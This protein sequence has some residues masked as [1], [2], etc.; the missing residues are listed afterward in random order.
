MPWSSDLNPFKIVFSS[1]L[2]LTDQK[3]HSSLHSWV[4]FLT[5]SAGVQP[6]APIP[7]KMNLRAPVSYSLCQK[8]GEILGSSSTIFFQCKYHFISYLELSFQG[9]G[10]QVH[11]LLWG[12]LLSEIRRP[13]IIQHVIA[14][15]NNGE[16]GFWK[17]L[18]CSRWSHLLHQTF[19]YY[20]V[21]VH[22]F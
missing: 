19:T 22:L 1:S 9:V 20:N 21:I 5:L 11:K 3:L 13:K 6:I 8:N 12:A 2:Y 18:L 17:V 10:H 16:K 15:D 4:L 14:T 7:I